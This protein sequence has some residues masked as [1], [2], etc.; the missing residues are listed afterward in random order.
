[1]LV[2]QIHNSGMCILP[3][4]YSHEYKIYKSDEAYL[5]DLYK[6]SR[7]IKSITGEEIPYYTRL[8]G[9]ST[10]LIAGTFRNK[11]IRE[12]LKERGMNYVDWNVSSADAASERVAK[13][14]IRENVINQCKDKKL[15][16]VLMHDSYYKTTT[17]AA[18]PEIINYLKR[19]G[20]VFRT[21]D[22]VTKEEEGEMVKQKILNR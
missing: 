8:P 19:E 14:R 3:H 13:E 21:F 9:G 1:M 18:L 20:F 4:T 2:R 6:C 15:A 7:V 17:V 12:I 16:V 22:D 5:D 11:R 10:N